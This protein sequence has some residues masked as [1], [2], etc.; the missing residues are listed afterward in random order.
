MAKIIN[1]F[2]YIKSKK[3][4]QFIGNV[5]GVEYTDKNAFN[6]AAKKAILENSNMLS[7]SSYE[8]YIPD[9]EN[10]QP[11]LK[12]RKK[13]IVDEDDFVIGRE[14]DKEIINGETFFIIP[15]GIKKKLKNCDNKDEISEC[16]R[17]HINNWE[18][19]LEEDDICLEEYK[20]EYYELK[21]KIEQKEKDIDEDS[22]GIRYYK[23]LLSHLNG[24]N[25]V[26]KCCC[27]KETKT[28]EEKEKEKSIFDLITEMT[29]IFENF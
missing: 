18:K 1:L 16:L 5:N 8:K 11:E 13:L 20:K 14:S 21:T 19:Y 22:A 9:V 26:G 3:M 7:I 12:T 10:K 6:E 27:E 17:K 15:S 23:T 29:N 24:K 28:I 25:P 4:K 2:K